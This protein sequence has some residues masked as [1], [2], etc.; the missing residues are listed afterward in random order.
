MEAGELVGP[1]DEAAQRDRRVEPLV[2]WAKE[3]EVALGEIVALARQVCGTT[4][5][6]LDLVTSTEQH[7][8]ASTW[9]GATAC[10]AEESLCGALLDEPDTVVIPDLTLDPRAVALGPSA[11]G[12]TATPGGGA[13][14]HPAAA[15]ARFYA[16][17][18][19]LAADGLPLGRLCVVDQDPGQ[20]GEGQRSSL[21]VLAAR[22]VD[23]LELQA[24]RAALQAA[25]ERVDDLRTDLD[26]AAEH[27]RLFAGQVSHDLRTPL[28]A[29]L[30]NAEMLAGEP[31]V[32]EDED[33]Q[34]MADGIVRAVHRMDVM[35][36]EMLRYARDAG[37]LSVGVVELGEL[38]EQVV[39]D[40]ALQVESA[41]ARVQVE[42]LPTVAADAHRIY[43]VL[44]NLITNA[45]TFARPDVAPEVTV[46]ARRR[47]ATWR[48][49]VS[50]NGRG[51]APERRE[52]MFVL[53]TRAD[54]RVEGAGL[55]LAL[56]KRAVEAHGGR[57]GMEPAGE[58][59]TT[60][61]FELPA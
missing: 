60:V 30:A 8:V 15:P 45:L 28:T 29:V 51:V 1:T 22:A 42:Q 17:A 7:T 12:P 31:A 16:S 57:I 48:V 27:L 59:G 55:G 26:R 40:L 56:A 54:K 36:E 10:P 53:F 46:T 38:A 3:G 41:G 25:E 32:A 6:A 21:A 5:A 11:A 47:G 18:P 43:G 34:W 44:R 13:G 37:E 20:L 2:R 52:A 39:A 19:L 24:T 61:W 49:S 33:V 58:V 14:D 4:H 50:D 9:N 35:V 23:V